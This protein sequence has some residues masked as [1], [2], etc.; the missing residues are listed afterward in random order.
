MRALEERLQHTPILPEE[1]PAEV[2]HY[3][4]VEGLHGILA[5]RKLWATDVRY[6]N[7]RSEFIY[8]D[9]LVRQV[10]T[11]LCA[12]LGPLFDFSEMLN[13]NFLDIFDCYVSCFCEDGDLLSQWRAYSRQGAGYAIGFDVPRLRAL[14]SADAGAMLGRIVYDQAAQ[15]ELLRE[16]L[17]SALRPIL[18]RSLI[19]EFSRLMDETSKRAAGL[20]A[21][22]VKQLIENTRPIV[23]QRML[24]LISGPVQEAHMRLVA[25]RAFMKFPRFSEEREWRFVVLR[26]A[27]SAGAVVFGTGRGV[28]VPRFA[29]D[30][31]DT[32][33]LPINRI[34][35]GPTLDP[36]AAMRSVRRLLASL[37]MKRVE[38]EVSPIPL[39]A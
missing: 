36:E 23:T 29:V 28:L 19:D 33:S 25:I 39:R 4:T 38:V 14:H 35:V 18:G 37:G 32:D 8:S 30:L 27:E 11:S 13:K 3:T 9:D 21:E 24:E 34:I 17:Q 12:G 1:E 2:F 31:G 6:L 7:D 22:E 20:S 26:P 5:T 16:S 10:G 15:L